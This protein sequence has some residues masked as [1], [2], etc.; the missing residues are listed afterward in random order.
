VFTLCPGL[1]VPHRQSFE[2]T[3]RDYETIN[4]VL[5]NVIVTAGVLPIINRGVESPF[6]HK[7]DFK[8]LDEEQRMHPL[9]VLRGYLPEPYDCLCLEPG[10]KTTGI[11][12]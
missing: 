12:D 10:W 7:N 4:G 1:Y 5:L 8:R 11:C 2:F 3:T 6:L 9:Q